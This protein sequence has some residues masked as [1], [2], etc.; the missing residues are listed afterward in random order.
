VATSS[1]RNRPLCHDGGVV[2]RLGADEIG[3]LPVTTE[4]TS[5]PQLTPEGLPLALAGREASATPMARA[6][7]ELEARGEAVTSRAVAESAHISPEYRVYLA[8][9]SRN[10]RSGGYIHVISCA[11]YPL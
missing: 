8:Q 3:Y 1:P 11:I 9:A 5:S 6:V 4:I 7:A 10:E 2:V